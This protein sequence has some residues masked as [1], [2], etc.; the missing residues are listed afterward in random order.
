[1]SFSRPVS[2]ALTLVGAAALALA[3]LAPAAVAQEGVAATMLIDTGHDSNEMTVTAQGENLRMD[4]NAGQGQMSMIWLPGRMLMVMHPQ[5]MYM[6]FTEEMMKRM[7][8]MMH[9]MPNMPDAEAEVPDFS[10]YTFERTGNTDTINGMSA[11]EVSM[12]GPDVD[13]DARLWMTED[14]D[15]GMFEVFSRMG[16]AMASMNLPMMSRGDSPADALRDYMGL[17]RAQGLPAGRV[18]RVVNTDNG[19][20]VTITLQSVQHGPFGADVF[21]APSDYTKQQMPMMQR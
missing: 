16:E 20:S 15:V 5:R 2:R 10:E 3:L 18:I 19:D 21:A 1:M 14:T 17:A 12:S 4:M 8:D 9:N 7:R 13:G 6:E 11:F